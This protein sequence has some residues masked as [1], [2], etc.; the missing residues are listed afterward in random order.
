[1]ATGTGTSTATGTRQRALPYFREIHELH[2]LRMGCDA[3]GPHVGHKLLNVIAHKAPAVIAVIHCHKV[4]HVP[5]PTDLRRP[6][7][8]DVGQGLGGGG[9]DGIHEGPEVTR[10]VCK[11]NN[12]RVPLVHGTP[13]RAELGEI[14]AVDSAFAAEILLGDV[15]CVPAPFPPFPPYSMSH[16]PILPKFRSFSVIAPQFLSLHPSCCQ[17]PF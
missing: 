1:M 3:L 16:G 7:P 9:L 8:H 2:G 17:F 5:D 14:I 10:A 15:P 13:A 11:T 6:A 4:C 12:A